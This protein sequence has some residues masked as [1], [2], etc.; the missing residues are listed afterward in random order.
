MPPTRDDT[1]HTSSPAESGIGYGLVVAGRHGITTHALP[2]TGSIILGRGKECDIEIPDDSVSRRHVAFH[3]GFPP[4]VED[5]GSHNGTYV[6]GRKLDPGERVAV[7]AGGVVHVGRATVVVQRTSTVSES[8]PELPAAAPTGPTLPP[9]Q[10]ED[11]VLNDPVVQDLYRLIDV[12]ARATISVLIRGETGVGKE[13]YAET[14]H[15]RSPRARRP[16]V[17]LN[18][19]AL[20]EGLLESEL[21]GHERGAFTGAAVAKTGLLEAA[22][23]GT[24]F[25]DEVGDLPLPMQAKLLRVL[26]TGELTRLGALR[27]K[28]VDFRLVSATNQDL[29]AMVA[30]GRFRTDLLF[31]INEFTVTLPPLRQRPADIAPLAERFAQRASRDLG[32]PAPT[33]SSAALHALQ[34]HSWPGNVRELRHVM[35]RATLLCAGRTIEPADLGSSFHPSEPVANGARPSKSPGPEVP[36]REQVESLEKERIVAA[37]ERCGWNQTRTAKRLGVSRRTLITKM[38]AYEIPRRRPESD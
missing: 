8:L 23:G 35:E 32:K 3:A 36:L 31:R 25:L 11:L 30:S 13:V 14:V 9:P 10:D 34:E 4:R 24:V 6:A 15:A 17:R 26:E 21:F 29:E 5:L 28:R 2:L 37:L 18:C 16:M 1:T 19:A 38:I 27:P 22:D 20:P 12:V 7:D 33:L